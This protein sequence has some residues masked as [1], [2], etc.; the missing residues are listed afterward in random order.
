[1]KECEG[2]CEKN[3]NN[4]G[5]RYVKCSTEQKFYKGFESTEQNEVKGKIEKCKGVGGEGDGSRDW[6][7]SHKHKFKTI[8]EME[9]Y[10]GFV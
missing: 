9:G 4:G 7:W 5:E 10:A 2:I 8:Y 6:Q 3:W 1:M